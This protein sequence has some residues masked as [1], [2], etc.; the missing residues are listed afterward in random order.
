MVEYTEQ[1]QG[2]PG[3]S[4][5]GGKAGTITPPAAGTDADMNGV[6]GGVP[7][8]VSG[9]QEAIADTIGRITGGSGG[10][11]GTPKF[12][13]TKLSYEIVPAKK[14]E[15]KA[16]PSIKETVDKIKAEAAQKAEKAPEP[17]P[18]AEKKVEPAVKPKEPEAKEPEI[19]HPVIPS[20]GFPEDIEHAPAPTPELSFGKK[21][22]EE[23]A[24]PE[25][26]IPALAQTPTLPPLEQPEAGPPK[27]ETPSSSAPIL[28]MSS[29]IPSPAPNPEVTELI[30]EVKT[31][32]ARRG[33]TKR[34]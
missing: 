8:P 5:L 24:A 26:Q 19:T 16:P 7:G 9:G 13:G 1:D 10:T 2:P 6:A 11:G 25:K 20:K 18:A 27:I 14:E 4:P 28:G 3:T 29:V 21:V 33:R 15:K 12:P 23:E 22:E 30:N 31:L 34:R 32:L 17:A